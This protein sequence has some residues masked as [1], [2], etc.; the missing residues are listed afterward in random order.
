MEVI[1]VGDAGIDIFMQ[2]PHIPRRDEKLRADSFSL[3]AGGMVA[4]FLCA[5]SRLGMPCG[6][7]GCV[8]GDQFG[9]IAREEFKR[10]GVDTSHLIVKEGEETFFTVVML[11]PSGEKA[12]VVA[13]TSTVY[14]TPKDLDEAYIAS[15]RHLHTTGL[16]VEEATAAIAI[17]KKHGL[18]VSADLDALHA[19]LQR[20]RKLIGG[21]DVLFLNSQGLRKLEE[22]GCSGREALELGPQVVVVTM[23]RRGSKVIT[24]EEEFDTP[25]FSVEVVDTTGAGDCFNAAFVYGY[26]QGWDYRR[27]ALFANAAAAISVTAMGSRSALP[28]REAVVDFLRSRGYDWP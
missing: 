14:P 3:F 8:G 25:G 10:F 12:L 26:L 19:G 23:G 24:P 16:D 18:T 27:T 20:L 13:V 22:E 21:T 17:A 6:F 15:A 9:A 11:D 5:L 28:T 1:G 2:V 7:L 4:N